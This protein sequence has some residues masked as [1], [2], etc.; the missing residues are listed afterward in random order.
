[1]QECNRRR[2]RHKPRQ[3]GSKISLYQQ[4]GKKKNEPAH[5]HHREQSTGYKAQP[6]FTGTDRYQCTKA[7]LKST[8]THYHN[9]KQKKRAAIYQYQPQLKPIHRE[10]K[11]KTTN[12]SAPPSAGPHDRNREEEGGYQKGTRQQDGVKEGQSA[13]AR[14]EPQSRWQGLVASN[15]EG[16]GGD[17]GLS[18]ISPTQLIRASV[19]TLEWGGARPCYREEENGK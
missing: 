2:K 17:L 16:E 19:V 12:T 5:H 4:T 3:Q 9:R 15:T 8:T 10:S 14:A 1:M 6:R 18:S 13:T 11:N 7:I